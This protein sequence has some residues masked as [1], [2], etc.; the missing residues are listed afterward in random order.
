MSS[1]KGEASKRGRGSRAEGREEKLSISFFI[2]I[3]S[4][5]VSAERGENRL[6]EEKEKI[7]W[8]EKERVPSFFLLGQGVSLFQG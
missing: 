7:G 4:K 3:S 1:I 2:L 6:L 5:I 8:Q